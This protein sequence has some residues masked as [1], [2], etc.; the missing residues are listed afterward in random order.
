MK[1]IETQIFETGEEL[2]KMCFA[3]INQFS[4]T[5]LLDG[6][7]N[8]MLKRLKEGGIVHFS[9]GLR[10]WMKGPTFIREQYWMLID[11]IG[12]WEDAHLGRW[13][14]TSTDD[15]HRYLSWVHQA[16]ATFKWKSETAD[17]FYISHLPI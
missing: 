3:F 8:A 13:P 2:E 15:Q 5:E 11:T 7:R 12:F 14:Y 1:T 6:T 17:I 10:E 16:I 4:P 9:R